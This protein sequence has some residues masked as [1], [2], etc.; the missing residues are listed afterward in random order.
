MNWH[1]IPWGF[2]ATLVFGL[3]LW[4][5]FSVRL[6]EEGAEIWLG[7]AVVLYVQRVLWPTCVFA[8][9]W[10]CCSVLIDGA[11]DGFHVLMG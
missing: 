7:E 11:V 10:F 1:V 2:W 8:V 5:T 9:F 6:I 4:A 3:S